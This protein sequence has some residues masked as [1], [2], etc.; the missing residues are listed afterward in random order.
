MVNKWLI[1]IKRS[2]QTAPEKARRLIVNRAPA[3]HM[4]FRPK[5]RRSA[6]PASSAAPGLAPAAVKEW[7]L[8]GATPFQRRT[9]IRTCSQAP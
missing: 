7:R 2:L 4:S 9:P 6:A 5:F 8:L 3:V 1:D